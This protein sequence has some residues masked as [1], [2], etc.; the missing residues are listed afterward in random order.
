MPRIVSP[1]E[2]RRRRGDGR[3]EDHEPR[4][5]ADDVRHRFTGALYSSRM[6]EG[7]LVLAIADLAFEHIH[8]G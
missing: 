3:R 2:L 6:N 4:G 7:L 8:W 1:E 5:H